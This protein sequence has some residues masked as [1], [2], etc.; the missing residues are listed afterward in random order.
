[1]GTAEGRTGWLP[2]SEYGELQLTA[3]EAPLRELLGGPDFDWLK[4]EGEGTSAVE[5]E[6]QPTDPE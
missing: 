1:M 5:C 2:P 6:L 4:D 3:M